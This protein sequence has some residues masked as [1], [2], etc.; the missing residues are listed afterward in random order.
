MP[1]I[2]GKKK[3]VHDLIEQAHLGVF[4]NNTAQS[5][6]AEFESQVNNILNQASSQAGKIGRQS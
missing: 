1:K 3:E 6:R 5:N 4:E 2:I